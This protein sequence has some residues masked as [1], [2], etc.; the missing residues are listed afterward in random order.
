MLKSDSTDS[1]AVATASSRPASSRLASWTNRMD[2]DWQRWYS[3][4][5]MATSSRTSNGSITVD[6]PAAWQGTVSAE[7]SLG[8]LN[9]SGGKVTGKGGSKSMTV[10]D[11]S[12]ATANIETSN[13]SVTVRSAK[14]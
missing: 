9:L 3:P 4:W 12:K 11:G 5:A 1:L 7:T 10:G 8:S 13:G 14:Q 6:L 2:S